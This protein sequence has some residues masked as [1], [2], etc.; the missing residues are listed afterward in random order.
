[1]DVLGEKMGLVFECCW[2]FSQIIVVICFLCQQA[3]PQI[4]IM[5]ETDARRFTGHLRQ[6][7]PFCATNCLIVCA[8]S[9]GS[10]AAVNFKTKS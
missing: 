2:D 3:S 9:L 7:S 5:R 10:I 4:L 6:D 8:M 1:M